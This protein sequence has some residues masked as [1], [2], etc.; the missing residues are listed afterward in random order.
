[1]CVRLVPPCCPRHVQKMLAAEMLLKGTMAPPF[2]FAKPHITSPSAISALSPDNHRRSA[3]HII[4]AV[5][6]LEYNLSRF[7]PTTS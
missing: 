4:I 6:G 2:T 7:R 5:R 3:A 1:M